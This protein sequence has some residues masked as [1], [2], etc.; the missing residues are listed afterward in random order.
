[1]NAPRRPTMA[2]VADLAGVSLKTASRVING[3]QG[4]SP[5][6]TKAVRQAVESL[7]YRSNRGAATL[8]SGSSTI[9]G[10]IVRDMSN[11][12]YSGLAAGAADSAQEHGL[13]LM[14]ASSEGDIHRQ[15]RLI[16]TM[17]EYRPRA[18]LITP[19]QGED[20]AL[21]YESEMGTPIVALDQPPDGITC[22][23]V[24][25]PNT[26]A[27][28]EAM[29][30]A[31]ST[32]ARTCGILLDDDSLKTMPARLQGVLSAIH[33]AGAPPPQDKHILRAHTHREAVAS[34]THLCTIAPDVEIIFCG[35]NVLPEGA[36]NSVLQ[37]GL[38][39]IVVAFDPLPLA[40]ELPL[41]II[42]ITHDSTIMGQLGMHA[43]LGAN[44][45]THSLCPTQIYLNTRM[46]ASH[47]HLTEQRSQS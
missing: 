5:S 13:L 3:S 39:P 17:M 14:T 15:S 24:S 32:G 45:P 38:S 8:R 4:V 26:E 10:L 43:A 35:N 36:I 44:P 41:R 16:D 28:K 18:L 29:S 12:F 27:T 6:K 42:T 46:R 9:V 23:Y 21:V 22:P 25:F 33:E 1:M 37:C 47:P 11:P 40:R 7:G 19:A 30:Q 2:E 31:L 34:T 20:P